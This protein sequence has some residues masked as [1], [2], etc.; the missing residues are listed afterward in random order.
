MGIEAASDFFFLKS[1]VPP[2]QNL[3][4]SVLVYTTRVHWDY[5]DHVECSLGQ[6]GTRQLMHEKGKKT[7][8]RRIMVKF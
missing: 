5:D 6:R 4:I 7:S 3:E 1:K 2:V 8:T